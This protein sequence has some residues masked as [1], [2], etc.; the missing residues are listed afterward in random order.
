MN[1]QPWRKSVKR[2]LL[3]ATDTRVLTPPVII[4]CAVLTVLIHLAPNGSTVH[5]SVLMRILLACLGYLP[6]L[7]TIAI[8]VAIAKG[9]SNENMRI[10]LMLTSYF[11]AGAL[12]G[13]VLS[14]GFFSLGM[15]DAL[16]LDFRIPGSALPFGLAI[17][18]ATYAVAALDESRAR[19]SSLRALEAEMTEAVRDSADQNAA[20]RDRTISKIEASIHL[21]L[22]PLTAI[23][24]ST[25]AD[26]LKAIASDVVRPLSH[27]L[28]ERVPSWQP[29]S[30]TLA[31]IR[32]TDIFS[33]IRP[34]LSL[35]PILLTA[36]SMG[37]GITAFI[38][39]F[40]IR[41][42][43]PMFLCSAVTLFFSTKGMQAVARKLP[44][45]SSLP[46]RVGVMTA[47]LVVL[48]IPAGAID[49][50]I[51]I[52]TNDPTFAL[53]AALVVVPLFGWFIALG[54]AAQ[55]ETARIEGDY[56]QKIARLSWLR[57]RLNLMNWHEQGELARVLHGPIQS[58]INRAVIM[59]TG[60]DPGS[61]VVILEELRSTIA[62]ELA[63]ERRWKTEGHTFEQMCA[64]LSFTWAEICKID[65]AIS[66]K[67]AGTLNNDAAATSLA[68]DIIHEC[69]NNALQHGKA[70]WVSV[71]IGDP[72]FDV[73]Q[74]EIID[75]GSQYQVGSQLGMGSNMIEACTIEWSRTRES[76]ETHLKASLPIRL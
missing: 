9:L 61:R 63:P 74:L 34:E 44:P 68:W 48:A 2:T 10:S 52:N 35:R 3:L 40:G 1:Q 36:L 58:I 37:T 69:C 73:I 13:V 76:N 39:F 24:T 12:R 62:R 50:V 59:L 57:A 18:V 54:G 30:G 32:W 15:A 21:E 45:I 7:A 51:A 65:F 75:N 23:T 17:A 41:L 43:I 33:Q 5:G 72:T 29:R 8:F 19:I 26:E 11:V 71:R 31:S 47:M 25:S 56:A 46:A 42:A 64:D 55:A 6:G 49:A 4:A 53:R 66:P 38:Y 22:R 14:V 28:A 70:S 20:L 67:A 27:S 60:A 16:N